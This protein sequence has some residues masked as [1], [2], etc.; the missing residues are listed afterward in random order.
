MSPIVALNTKAAS[1]HENTDKDVLP[2][3]SWG[4][5]FEYVL[6]FLRTSDEAAPYAEALNTPEGW[7][8][9]AEKVVSRV[10]MSVGEHECMRDDVQAVM[11]KI[12]VQDPGFLTTFVEPKGVHNSQYLDC[13][14]G[15]ANE[16]HVKIAEWVRESLHL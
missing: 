12:P 4:E 6:P 3:W 7:F 16:L 2:E 15:E 10:W 14:A 1:H 5:L 11:N 9:G 13:M 8:S